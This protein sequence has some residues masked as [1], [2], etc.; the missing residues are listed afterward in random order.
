MYSEEDGI[1]SSAAHG[2]APRQAAILTGSAGDCQGI[3][4]GRVLPFFLL[5]RLTWVRFDAC[6]GL[7]DGGSSGQ[8]PL[9]PPKALARTPAP[10]ACL[11]APSTR[12]EARNSEDR[13]MHAASMTRFCALSATALL[14]LT[15]PPVSAAV[16]LPN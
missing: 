3:S 7:L 1:G 15:G 4:R 10:H 8:A 11:T 13:G 5:R 12:M 6:E 9:P 14:V 2:S 16:V